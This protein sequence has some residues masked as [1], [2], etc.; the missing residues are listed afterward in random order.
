MSG[1]TRLRAKWLVSVGEYLSSGRKHPLGFVLLCLVVAAAVLIMETKEESS[2]LNFRASFSVLQLRS[3]TAHEAGPK[4]VWAL[5][6]HRELLDRAIEDLAVRKRGGLM[7]RWFGGDT[8]YE[9]LLKQ[10]REALAVETSDEEVARVAIVRATDALEKASELLD[11]ITSHPERGQSQY[12]YCLTS[13]QKKEM[14]DSFLRDQTRFIVEARRFLATPDEDSAEHACMQSRITAFSARLGWP[15]I[16]NVPDGMDKLIEFL[17]VL[18]DVRVATDKLA[19]DIA[20]KN[21]DDSADAKR[22]RQFALSQETRIKVW[23]A[24]IQKDSNRARQIL[25]VARK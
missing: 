16:G 12:I 7:G 4:Y 9:S 14:L 21:G 11:K 8:N 2:A 24:L 1:E 3:E 19:S 18:G 17:D 10:A 23:R 20:T 5:A 22:L 13:V 25:L 15:E 6:V